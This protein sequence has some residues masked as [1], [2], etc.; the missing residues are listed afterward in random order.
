MAV[1]DA[2]A[3]PMMAPTPPARVA[4]LFD[5]ECGVCTQSAAWFGRRD[6]AGRIQRLDLRDPDAAARFPTLDPVAVRALMHVV[7]PDGRVTIGLD[8]VR[9]VLVEL[10]GAWPFVARVLGI[11]GVHFVAEFFYRAF[12]RNRLFFNRW[13]TPARAPGSEVVC[14]GD[15][16]AIDWEALARSEEAHQQ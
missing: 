9:A 3:G 14:E 1:F 11:P 12:A 15:A 6:T 4:A 2:T 16:C 5:G 8:A 13:F 10:P 7:H